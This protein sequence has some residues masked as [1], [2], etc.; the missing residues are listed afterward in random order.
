MRVY[1]KKPA[2]VDKSARIPM[3]DYVCLKVISYCI[4]LLDEID[5]FGDHASS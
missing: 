2:C 1:M 3:R 4:P 5:E